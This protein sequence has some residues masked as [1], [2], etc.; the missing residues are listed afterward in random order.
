MPTSPSLI[1]CASRDTVISN[2]LPPRTGRHSGTPVTVA[3]DSPR[4]TDFAAT[5][6]AGGSAWVRERPA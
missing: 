1:A 6:W 3:V 5:D 2:A 4:L